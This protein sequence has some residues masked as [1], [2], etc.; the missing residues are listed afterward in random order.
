LVFFRP[1]YD[2]HVAIAFFHDWDSSM[3]R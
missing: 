3:A 2:F 1:F